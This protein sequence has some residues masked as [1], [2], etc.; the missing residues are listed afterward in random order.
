MNHQ[1]R[2]ISLSR[3]TG[4]TWTDLS[5]TV[6]TWTG[7][8]N[9]LAAFCFALTISWNHQTWSSDLLVP[10][11]VC[12]LGGLVMARSVATRPWR[13]SLIFSTVTTIVL[14]IV[15]EITFHIP[16]GMAV[17]TL[18]A[19]IASAALCL[20]HILQGEV[21]SGCIT[22][23]RIFTGLAVAN[24]LVEWFSQLSAPTTPSPS[25]ILFTVVISIGLLFGEVALARH[26]EAKSTGL[27]QQATLYTGAGI[28]TLAVLVAGL[29]PMVAGIAGLIIFAILAFVISPVIAP[30]VQ[31]L[32]RWL[33]GKGSSHHTT[34]QAQSIHNSSTQHMPPAPATSSAL[35][36]IVWAILVALMLAIILV[37]LLTRRQKEANA[38]NKT[39]Q[40]QIETKTIVRQEKHIDSFTL[41]RTDQPT[42][43]AMQKRLK[44][45][46]Q[47]GHTIGRAETIRELLARLPDTERTTADIE[48]AQAYERARYG[49]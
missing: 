15:G 28:M 38:T 2:S 33:H 45:W 21:G 7:I 37:Y 26:V 4:C 1:A 40:T 24:V 39:T 11:A 34:N 36:W 49:L 27:T 46:H 48:L 43:L 17:A 8:L 12:V 14:L 6:Q 30:L 35:H 16:T 44:A 20:P 29:G 13:V 32:L 5:K 3:P 41:E 42:R 19:G 23:L 47:K 31:Q 10:L 25:T 9:G 22:N 18:F